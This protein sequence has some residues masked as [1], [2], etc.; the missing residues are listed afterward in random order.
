MWGWRGSCTV[1]FK[2]NKSEDV[3]GVCVCVEGGITVPVRSN[4]NITQYVL[5]VGQ[6]PVQGGG[7]GGSCDKGPVQGRAGNGKGGFTLLH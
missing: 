7:G 2:V 5:R 1:T 4:M 6:G 3:R